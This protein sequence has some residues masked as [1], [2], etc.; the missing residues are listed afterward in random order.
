MTFLSTSCSLIDV[1]RQ[2]IQCE[3]E[4]NS[5]FTVSYTKLATCFGMQ[6]RQVVYKC[7]LCDKKFIYTESGDVYEITRVDNHSKPHSPE[8]HTESSNYASSFLTKYLE[9]YFEN[10][11]DKANALNHAFSVL[12]IPQD[13]D[14]VF[15]AMSTEALGK[16]YLRKSMSYLK[17]LHNSPITGAEIF[18][19]RWK[20]N[21]PDDLV[22]FETSDESPTDLTFVYADSMM[23][24]IAKNQMIFHIDSTYKLIIGGIPL[25]A[26]T[27]KTLQNHIIPLCYFI[28]SKETSENIGYCLRKYFE[29]AGIEPAA[30]MS[31]AGKNIVK[32][33]TDNFKESH[34][35][36]CILHVIRA[37]QRN[38][39]R[40]TNGKNYQRCS[41]ILWEL[42]NSKYEEEKFNELFSEFDTILTHEKVAAD[43]FNLQWISHLHNICSLFRNEELPK[44]NNIAESHF[45]QLKYHYFNSHRNLR[46]DAVISTL[47]ENVIPSMKLRAQMDTVLHGAISI[48]LLRKHRNIY[49]EKQ[50]SEDKA[51]CLELIEALKEKVER[52]EID[53]KVAEIHIKNLI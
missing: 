31:D 11:G 32:A 14:Q 38:S 29:W 48:G 46:L 22:I 1:L 52:D 21:F 37:F 7:K 41:E 26:L 30:F 8:E 50:Y 24:D 34:L 39:D 4:A 42:M 12:K 49:Y 44:T 13:F 18:L 33:I 10:G 51:H 15:L 6:S 9:I 19:A 2:G 53:P 45:R 27:G 47:L 5:K 16:H 40:F 35:Y 3:L 17:K 20:R 36:L 25:F 43:Y 28:I 23:I